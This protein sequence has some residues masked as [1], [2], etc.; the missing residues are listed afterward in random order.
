MWVR[1][2]ARVVPRH[3]LR[4]APRPVGAKAPG[5]GKKRAAEEE[6][7]FSSGSDSEEE[8]ELACPFPRRGRGN[9]HC[10]HIEL[11]AGGPPGYYSNQ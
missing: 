7:D 1:A 10:G 11:A 6:P 4:P 8:A 9:S 2:V 3:V 5:H